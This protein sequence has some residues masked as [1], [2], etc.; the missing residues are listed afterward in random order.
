MLL[1]ADINTVTVLGQKL[2]HYTLDNNETGLHDVALDFD[3]PRIRLLIGDITNEKRMMRA[4]Q[5]VDL[6]FHAGLH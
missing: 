3:D 4:M 6:V 2:W 5:N 1:K